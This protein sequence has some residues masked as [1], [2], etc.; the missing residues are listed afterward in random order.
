VLDVAFAGQLNSHAH[1]VMLYCTLEAALQ[2]SLLSPSRR[3]AVQTKLSTRPL[4]KHTPTHTCTYSHIRTQPHLTAH[5][6]SHVHSLTYHPPAPLTSYTDAHEHSLTHHR[7]PTYCILM[8]GS[9]CG[10][11]TFNF[12]LSQISQSRDSKWC[13]ATPTNMHASPLSPTRMLCL[14]HWHA[15]ASGHADMLALPHPLT[16]MRRLPHRNECFA[17]LT[18]MHAPLATLT[19]LRCHTH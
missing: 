14:P 15:C 5:T 9:T 8:V 6:N 19:C 3:H 18:G 2:F 16:C 17:S 11:V 12:T 7:P 1:D 13:V 4:S 10:S